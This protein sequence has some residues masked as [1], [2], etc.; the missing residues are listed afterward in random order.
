MPVKEL[1]IDKSFVIDLA[2][3]KEDEILVKSTIDLTHNLGLKVTAEGVE[4]ELSLH[5]L[6]G[7]GCD[8]AQGSFISKPLPI[9]DL[10]DFL[11][12]SAFGLTAHQKPV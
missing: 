9:E 6:K 5:I 10:M 2:K 12:N 7:F 11:E 3:N 4:D 1:K 8:V